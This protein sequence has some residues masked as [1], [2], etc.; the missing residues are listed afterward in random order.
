VKHIGKRKQLQRPQESSSTRRER[1]RDRERTLYLFD[2]TTQKRAN[3]NSVTFQQSVLR[4]FKSAPSC[5]G[6]VND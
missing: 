6:C 2:A 4:F 3:V 5:F 1:E